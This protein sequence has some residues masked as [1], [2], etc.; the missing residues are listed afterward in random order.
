[1]TFV[2]IVYTKSADIA[3]MI[4]VTVDASKMFSAEAFGG[5]IQQNYSMWRL[6][7]IQI[8]RN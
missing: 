8:H 6:H 5:D 1:M 4:D 2:D 3:S 7:L